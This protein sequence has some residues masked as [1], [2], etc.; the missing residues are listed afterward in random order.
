MRKDKEKGNKSGAYSSSW[1]FNAFDCIFETFLRCPL[2]DGYHRRNP[3]GGG[4]Y[5]T[6]SG[7]LLSFEEKWGKTSV[8]LVDPISHAP[9]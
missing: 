7:L 5:G 2:G 8:I 6:L 9:G 3:L 1:F 4:S